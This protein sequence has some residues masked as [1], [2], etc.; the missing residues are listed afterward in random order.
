MTVFGGATAPN[1]NVGSNV[2]LLSMGSVLYTCAP[3]TTNQQDCDPTW[4]PVGNPALN[5]EF[6]N[7]D[8]VGTTAAYDPNAQGVWTQNQSANGSIRRTIR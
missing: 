3:T 4:T 5:N 6:N 1:G 2:W 7:T 8:A